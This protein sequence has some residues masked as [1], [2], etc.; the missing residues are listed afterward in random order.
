MSFRNNTIYVQQQTNCLFYN[1]CDF[2]KTYVNN[3]IIFNKILNEHLNHLIKIFNLFK[4]MNIAI[5]FIR[6]YFNY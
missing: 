5:K 4:R 3:I 1:Y 6:I 2:I